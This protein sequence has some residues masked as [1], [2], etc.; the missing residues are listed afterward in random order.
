MKIEPMIPFNEEVTLL[1]DLGMRIVN[2]RYKLNG[3]DLCW[4]SAGQVIVF[5]V[6]VNLEP[7][8]FEGLDYVFTV[9]NNT[10]SD[11]VYEHFYK[12]IK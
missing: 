10:N 2:K 8:R 9:H 7:K 3:E 1:E 4:C 11:D 12:E 5:K 6:G